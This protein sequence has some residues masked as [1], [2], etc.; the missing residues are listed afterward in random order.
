MRD[1]QSSNDDQIPVQ[2][3]RRAGVPP[4]HLLQPSSI[5][6]GDVTIAEQMCSFPSQ[7][8]VNFALPLRRPPYEGLGVRRLFGEQTQWRSFL[9]Q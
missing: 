9:E 8:Q 1:A 5:A 7:S 6:I 3:N 4:Y 2:S